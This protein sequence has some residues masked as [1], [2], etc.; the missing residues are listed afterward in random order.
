M[1]SN[2]EQDRIVLEPNVVVVDPGLRKPIE[3]S[4]IFLS[5]LYY[6]LLHIC[7]VLAFILG[8]TRPKILVPPLERATGAEGMETGVIN[9]SKGVR[10]DG[11]G[12]R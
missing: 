12:Q 2:N 6:T 1:A 3:Q 7:Q 5:N 9:R 11:T 10:R 4:C 8:P